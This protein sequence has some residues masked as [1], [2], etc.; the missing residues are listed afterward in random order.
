MKSELPPGWSMK[1]IDDLARVVTGATPKAA[2][3][4]HFGETV[5]FLTPSDIPGR[6]KQVTTGRFLSQAG[7]MAFRN[8]LVPKGTPCFVAIGSTIGKTCV[9][10]AQ[11]LTNQQIHATIPK[12]SA[13]DGDFL[14]YALTQYAKR[15]RKIAGGSA[16]PILKKSDFEKFTIPVPSLDEQRRVARVLS[17]LDDKIDSNRRLARTLEEIA[18]ALFKARFVD[19]IG[20]DDL[21]EKE[22]GSIPRGWELCPL[23]QVSAVLTR[24]RAPIYVDKG[25]T[26]VVNQKCV[27]GRRVSFEV[28]RRHDEQTRNSE[29]RRLQLGDVLINSTGVGTLGRVSQVCWLPEPA[30][31]DGHVTLVRAATASMDQDYLALSLMSHQRDFERMGH[32]STGQTELIRSQLAEMQILVPPRKEQRALSSFYAPLREQI[33]ALERQTTVVSKIRDGLMPKLISGDLRPG[34]MKTRGGPR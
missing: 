15:L 6:Q 31:L 8:K 29:D 24:G 19:F 12:P 4:E 10:P 16:T 1:R 17:A 26:L 21:V 18:A 2:N 14:H 9:A 25:G 28:A 5:P 30:T 20:H 23:G 32:G 3:P 34:A 33:G 22:T 11:S 7:A 13:A 27:R